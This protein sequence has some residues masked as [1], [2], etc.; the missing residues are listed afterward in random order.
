M[1]ATLQMLNSKFL[2]VLAA[3]L[4]VGAVAVFSLS[5]GDYAQKIAQIATY[6]ARP[7]GVELQFE[8]PNLGFLSFGASRLGITFPAALIGLVI[9]EFQLKASFV[10]LL[11]LNPKIDFNAQA[12]GGK[13]SGTLNRLN[14]NESPKLSAS[15]HSIKIGEHRQIAALG[16]SGDLD[17]TDSW[18]ELMPKNPP[19]AELHLSIK[20]GKKPAPTQI[21]LTPFG[22]PFSVTLPPI[23]WFNFGLDGFAKGNSIEG[24]EFSMASSLGSVNGAGTLWL[25]NRKLIERI[26]LEVK[27]ALTEAGK[28]EFGAIVALTSSGQVPSSA[29]EFTAI[30]TG[31]ALR[32]KL[33]FKDIQ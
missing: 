19:Q 1:L 29:S 18:V 3:L 23:A 22:A 2:K 30:F 26:S 9:Q 17:I 5:L 31:P 14:T 6:K 24:L 10:S 4:L 8:S 33:E 27:V 25:S 16:I 15:G 32:P 13:I 7:L 21:D 20:D 11:G 12:Y 28:R